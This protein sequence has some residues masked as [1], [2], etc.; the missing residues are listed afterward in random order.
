VVESLRA[1]ALTR[2]AMPSVSRRAEQRGALVASRHYAGANCTVNAWFSLLYGTDGTSF[3]RFADV[4]RPVA[5]APLAWLR[6]SGYRLELYTSESLVWQDMGALFV[7]PAFDV[8]VDEEGGETW[9]RDARL[10]DRY[11]ENGVT[12][13]ATPRLSVLFFTSSHHDYDYPP[14]REPFQPA[15]R[16]LDVMGTDLRPFRA[17]LVNRYLSS[18][19]YVDELVGVLLDRLEREGRLA[20]TRVVI[21][22]DHGEEFLEHGHLT[23]ASSLV[24]EQIHVPL[25]LLGIPGLEGR[26]STPTSHAQILPTLL[27]SISRELDF[28][29][30]GTGVPIG[31]ASRAA[32]PIPI[33]SECASDP[34]M[35]VAIDG[36]RKHWLTIDSGAIRTDFV[37]DMR[38]AIV[39]DAVMPPATM[40]RVRATVAHFG[41][42]AS[43]GDPLW[44]CPTVRAGGETFHLCDRWIAWPEA[45][46]VCESHGLEL[47]SFTDAA[48]VDAVAATLTAGPH[49]SAWIGLSDAEHEGDFRWL[50]GSPPARPRWSAGEPSNT[51]G[52]EHCA[53]V[54]RD[55]TW[56]DRVCEARDVFVCG[57]RR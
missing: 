31:A 54:Q 44:P 5:S 41:R 40:A 6:Q 48:Q 51:G 30:V 27:A 39:P 14:G 55:G 52:R 49:Q 24:E 57:P 1:D 50:D 10:L 33:V 28:A 56:V 13:G 11:F 4:S 20:R 43:F 42:A 18:V 2:E 46:A 23:H 19:S 9:E 3:A 32:R 15:L 47:A 17:E 38:D 22:G 34:G 8:I 26:L 25:V 29:N 12:A 21:T 16:A 45:R 7:E 36:A 53:Q 35:F 37:S